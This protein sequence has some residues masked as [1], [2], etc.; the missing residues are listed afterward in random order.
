MQVAENVP[1]KFFRKNYEIIIFFKIVLFF[2]RGMIIGSEQKTRT[3]A[4]STVIIKQAKCKTIFSR[5]VFRKRKIVETISKNFSKVFR[6]L[7]FLITKMALITNFNRVKIIF[8]G[9]N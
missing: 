7:K 5:K 1:T 4:Y 8:Q 9:L 3:Q 2:P 6:I